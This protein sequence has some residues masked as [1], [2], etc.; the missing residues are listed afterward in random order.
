VPLDGA[1]PF[2][3]APTVRFFNPALA[4]EDR[5]DFP[6]G[7]DWYRMTAATLD[8]AYTIVFI[9]PA[10][11]GAHVTYL[12]DRLRQSGASDSTEWR[13]GSGEHVCKG[14]VFRPEEAVS[15]SV[16]IALKRLPSGT[17][18]LVSGYVQEG[19]YLLAVVQGYGTHDARFVPDAFEEND[20]CR[21]ADDNF[22]N[23]ATHID[24][25]KP[26][27]E[28]MTIDNAHDVDWIRFRVSGLLPQAVAIR[29][30]PQPFGAS[31]RS[32]IDLYLMTVPNGNQGLNAVTQDVRHGSASAIDA[33]LFPGDYYL[34]VVDSAGVPTRYGLC[35]AVGSSCTTPQPPPPAATAGASALSALSSYV[36]T[37]GHRP[38]TRE[39]RP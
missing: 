20:L 33:V 1:P 32:D 6:F 19:R 2:A 29:T 12:T 35:I 5:R 28:N 38:T 37:L 10:L 23:P 34:A 17:M 16:V 31:D 14:Y 7:F 15:D 13:L 4:F 30:T 11:G 18:D 26:F 3:A 24:L 22:A 9:A 39:D 36:R 8:S 21:F 27:A 25:S